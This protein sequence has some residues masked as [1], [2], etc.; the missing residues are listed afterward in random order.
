METE[1]NLKN[2][3]VGEE[4]SWENH[5]CETKYTHIVKI[6]NEKDY[7]NLLEKFTKEK[8]SKCPRCEGEAYYDPDSSNDF[9]TTR[10][11]YLCCDS[12]CGTYYRTIAEKF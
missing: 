2:L 12:S 10:G 4:V 11:H 7:N 5:A 8:K 3:K 9:W 1:I 6:L